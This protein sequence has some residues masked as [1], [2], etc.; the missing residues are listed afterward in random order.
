MYFFTLFS[1]IKIKYL[2]TFSDSGPGEFA[3]FFSWGVGNVD[4]GSSNEVT[5]Q[6]FQYVNKI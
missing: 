3:S 5:N 6:I 4:K 1:G 2:F